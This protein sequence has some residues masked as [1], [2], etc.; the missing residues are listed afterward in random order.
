MSHPED[1]IQAC[2]SRLARDGVGDE[3]LA[4]GAFALQGSTGPRVGPA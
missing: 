2:Q 4:A 3:V 1:L